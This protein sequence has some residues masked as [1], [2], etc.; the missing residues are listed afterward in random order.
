MM[1]TTRSWPTT[2]FCTSRTMRARSS[3]TSSPFVGHARRETPERE[4]FVVV[5][6]RTEQHR[7]LVVVQSEAT[8]GG[9]DRVVVCVGSETGARPYPRAGPVAERSERAAAV[10]GPF[11]RVGECGDIR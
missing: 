3:S 2:T 4:G 5:L 10:A 8:C 7:D 11:Q 1:S 6:R 9:R